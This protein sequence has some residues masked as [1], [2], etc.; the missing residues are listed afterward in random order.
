LDLNLG[1]RL[2]HDTRFGS[3]LSPRT[4]LGITPWSGARLK[5]IYAQAFRAPSAYELSY[6]DPSSQ[7]A[8]DALDPESVRSIETS[9]EQR[10]GRN[11]VLFGVFRSVWSGMV[12]ALALTDAELAQAV[13]ALRQALYPRVAPL[14]NLWQER[15]R[16]DTRF[17]PSLDEYLAHCHAAGQQRPTPLIL[18]YREGDFNCLH[19]DLYGDLVFPL[20]ATVLLSAPG[21]DFDGGEFMLIEQRPRMQS[22]GEVVPLAQGD[23]VVFAVNHR[24]PLLC[25]LAVS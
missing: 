25:S 4:A 21:R 18:K 15:L 5:L 1:V 14:A 17:P 24:P 23:A 9:I 16:L 2:D 6:S 19:Q 8:V 11:R 7:V 3:A 20:Q 13:A 22:R 10:F 12:G